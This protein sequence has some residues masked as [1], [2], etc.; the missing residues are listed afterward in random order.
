MAWLEDD[1]E[2]DT[3]NILIYERTCLSSFDDPKKNDFVWNWTVQK[4]FKEGC[5]S[6]VYPMNFRDI[7]EQKKMTKLLKLFW[8]K[9]F[10]KRF[11]IVIF[12]NKKGNLVLIEINFR[13]FF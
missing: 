9:S 13:F 1:E 2:D 4:Y 10:K 8:S 12:L 7:F 3:Q 11:K 6:R 5:N